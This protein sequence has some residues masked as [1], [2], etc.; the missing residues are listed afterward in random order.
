LL[1]SFAALRKEVSIH[2]QEVK[3]QNLF[4]RS[5]QAPCE[6]ADPR[7]CKTKGDTRPEEGESDDHTS[8]SCRQ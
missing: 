1:L 8:H 6:I 7:R 2:G 3:A 4:C 5:D